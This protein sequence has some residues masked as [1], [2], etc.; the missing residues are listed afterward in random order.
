MQE[1]ASLIWVADDF[2]VLLEVALWDICILWLSGGKTLSCHFPGNEKKQTCFKI[3]EQNAVEDDII[4]GMSAFIYGQIHACI[5]VYIDP[6]L[7]H[8]Y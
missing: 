5:I 4:L 2:V 7:A 1:N 8:M 3:I 6:N